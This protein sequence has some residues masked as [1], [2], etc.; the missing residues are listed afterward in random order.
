MRGQVFF[1]LLGVVTIGIFAL[2]SSIASWACEPGEGE[3]CVL[4]DRPRST[5][6]ELTKM[7]NGLACTESHVFSS[8]TGGVW[9]HRCVDGRVEIAQVAVPKTM[10]V[11]KIGVAPLPGESRSASAPASSP[12]PKTDFEAM[13]GGIVSQCEPGRGQERCLEAHKNLMQ[14]AES[15]LE[16]MPV[17]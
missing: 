16:A 17:P 10:V 13:L 7:G 2:P 1:L 12:A 6:D 8:S 14:A 3:E 9:D 5:P 4:V 11:R 15:A